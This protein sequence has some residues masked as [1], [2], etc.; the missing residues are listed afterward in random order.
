MAGMFVLRI[1]YA[2]RDPVGFASCEVCDQT[3]FTAIV[4]SE[5]VVLVLNQPSVSQPHG[6][7][8]TIIC[9]LISDNITANPFKPYRFSFMA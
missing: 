4:A 5:M 8:F 1:H 9:H 7:Y 2:E 3:P 6:G